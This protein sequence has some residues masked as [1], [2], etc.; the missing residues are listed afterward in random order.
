MTAS[1]DPWPCL[2]SRQDH[3]SEKIKAAQKV[4]RKRR[5]GFAKAFEDFEVLNVRLCFVCDANAVCDLLIE[6]DYSSCKD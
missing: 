5:P 3:T 4:Y 6:R 1:A 2:Y